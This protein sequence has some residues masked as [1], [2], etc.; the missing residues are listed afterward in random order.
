VPLRWIAV[1]V[2]V[3]SSVLNYLDRQVLATMA[4][5]WRLRH[6]FPVTPDYGL[7]VTVFSIAYA[8]SAPFMGWFLD[9]VGLNRGISISVA[10]WAVASAGTGTVHDMTGLLIWRSALGVAEAAGISGVGKVIGMYLL[11]EERA[12]GQATSQLGISVGAA[13]APQF[14]VLLAYHFNWRWAFFAAGI[15]SLLWIPLWLT[16]TRLIPPAVQPRAAS[17]GVHSEVLIRDARFW[18]LIVANGLSMTL[19]SL[20]TNWTPKYLVHMGLSPSE[21]AKYSWVVP[22]CGYAGS[23][24]GGSLSWRFIRGGDTPIRARKRVCLLAAIGCLATA[25][26]PLTR[27]FEESMGHVPF[28]GC[29]ATAIVPLTRAP[30][31]ATIG[32]SFSFLAIA[33]W[34]SNLYTLPV[35]IFGAA[36]AGFAT[37]GLVFA[38]GAMQAII[39]QPLGKVVERW[40]FAPVCV[41]FAALPMLAYAILRRYVPD[42]QERV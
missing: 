7:L 21:A 33:A 37:S 40:G 17:G 9:R 24:L 25:L 11:P 18:A 38:Y 6:D 10:L 20:W 16:T 34:S 2:F 30:L 3:L 4:D 36:R 22:L 1:V 14:T 42:K 26:V 8:I 27:P 41:A 19:Y 39:S 13:L 15:L 23:F 29:L 35:D 31:L 32:M 12:V 28:I 5:I